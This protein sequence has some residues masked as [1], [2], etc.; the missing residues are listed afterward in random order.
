MAFNPAVSPH[1]P[2]YI[3]C[4]YD[5]SAMKAYERPTMDVPKNRE[6]KSKS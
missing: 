5:P 3:L 1:H 6:R 4:Q 2:P